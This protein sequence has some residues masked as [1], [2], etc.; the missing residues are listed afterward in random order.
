VSVSE[1]YVLCALS[2]CR[3]TFTSHSQ[4]LRQQTRQK[5]I[6]SFLLE[7]QSVLH[8]QDRVESNQDCVD[9]APYC[10]CSI[11]PEAEVETTA[12]EAALNSVGQY[13]PV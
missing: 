10:T 5:Q 13:S 7:S 4:R 8:P 1:A 12:R 3:S 6:D 2:V 11:S 9:F